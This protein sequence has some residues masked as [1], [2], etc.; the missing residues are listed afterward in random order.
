MP[1]DKT[2]LGKDKV[3]AAPRHERVAGG[4]QS[5]YL[6]LRYVRSL[7]I[8]ARPPLSYPPLTASFA[9]SYL[10]DA[11]AV[12]EILFFRSAQ[13]AKPCLRCKHCFLHRTHV[14]A[15]ISRIKRRRRR[16]RQ[17]PVT[18]VGLV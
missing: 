8:L 10:R 9:N 12:Q 7:Y 11:V 13:L 2:S 5:S 4:T 18:D 14:V 16:R 1:Q 15:E 3:G 6:L 17:I